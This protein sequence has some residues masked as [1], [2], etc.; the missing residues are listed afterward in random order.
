MNEANKKKPGPKKGTVTPPVTPPTPEEIEI[1]KAEIKAENLEKR[2]REGYDPK[3]HQA[4]WEKTVH[5]TP[6]H[7]P[8]PRA[9]SSTE[10][11]GTSL[12]ERVESIF[13]IL[14]EKL[15]MKKK[16]VRPTQVTRR[17]P[18]KKKVEAKTPSGKKPAFEI[19]MEKFK[20]AD[21][22]VRRD[23]PEMYKKKG[24]K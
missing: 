14:V 1:L 20:A 6:G 11:E 15:A 4:K 8:P 24:D 12:R 13:N 16:K 5:G 22:A 19:A 7:K 23:Y 9:N 21:D 10:Y 3:R 2:R 18:K 17:W